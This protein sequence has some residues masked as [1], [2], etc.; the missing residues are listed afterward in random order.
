[1][2]APRTLVLGLGSPIMGDDGFGLVALARL[3][4]RWELPD[5]VR[6]LDGGTWGMN[7][8]P[9][10][11]ASEHLVLLDAV[12]SGAAPGTVVELEGDDLPRYFA[13]KLSPHQVDIRE[14][15]AACELRGTLPRTVAA[16]GAQAGLLAMSCDLS[17]ECAAAVDTVADRCAARLRAL[18]HDLRPRAGAEAGAAEVGALGHRITLAAAR[19]QHEAPCTS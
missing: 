18:G 19:R 12:N 8:L 1:M 6:R 3:E 16:L 17:A 2:T 14:V 4:A 9:D 11:E 15:L 7:L 10:I 5:D 13:L